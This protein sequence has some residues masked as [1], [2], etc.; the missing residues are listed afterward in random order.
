MPMPEQPPNQLREDR[1]PCLDDLIEH[2]QTMRGIHG[3]IVVVKSEDDVQS[4]GDYY[5]IDQFF[6]NWPDV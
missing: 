4:P 5:A 2:L 6:T 1:L 3:N